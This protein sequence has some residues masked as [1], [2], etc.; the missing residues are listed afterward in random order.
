MPVIDKP[1]P[2]YPLEWLK[3]TGATDGIVKEDWAKPV[4][5]KP[6]TKP[7]LPPVDKSFPQIVPV[8]FT[9]KVPSKAPA[10]KHVSFKDVCI[11]AGGLIVYAL[12]ANGLYHLLDYLL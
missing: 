7:V 12:A 4:K 3:R 9:P 2:T 11:G 8:Q 5:T 10:K 1:V 6:L